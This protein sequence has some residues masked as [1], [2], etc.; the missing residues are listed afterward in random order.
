[1]SWVTED[2]L[3]PRLAIAQLCQTGLASREELARVFQISIRSVQKYVQVFGERGAGGLAAGKRGP[4]GRWK[5]SAALRGEILFIALHEGI[6]DCEGIRRRLEGWGEDVSIPS[7]R[8]VLLENGIRQGISVPE[9]KSQQR[10]LL[11]PSEE[12]GQ[13]WLELG[14][15]NMPAEQTVSPR[16]SKQ[17]EEEPAPRVTVQSNLSRGMRAKRF[18]SRAQRVYLDRLEHGQYSAYAGGLLLIPLVGQYSFLPVLERTLDVGSRQGHA[19]Q[20]LCLTLLYMDVFRF[21]SL[22]DFKRAYRREFG[23]LAGRLYSPSHFTLRRFLHE[24]RKLGKGEEL[25]EQFAGEYLKSGIARWGVLYIDGHFLPYHGMFPITKGW[26]AVRK[27]P[28]KGSYHFIAVDEE[29][30][31]WMFLIRSSSEDLR[32]KIPEI[33]EKVKRIARD[34]GLKEKEAERIIVVFDREGYS[35]ELYRCL[36]GRDKDDGKRRAIFIS[37]AKYTKWVYEIPEEELDGRVVVRYKIRKPKKF[38]Y[39]ETERRMPK[40]GKIRTV[41][42]QREADKKR[43]AIYTNGKAQELKTETVVRIMCRRW[44][45][46]NLIKSLMEKHFINYTP[47]YVREQLAE[48]P[49]VDNPKVLELKKRKARLAGTVHKAKARFTDE[50]L[51]EADEESRLKE[52]KEGQPELLQ[53]IVTTESQILLI[54]LEIDK[55]P[56]KVPFQQAHA[57]KRLLKLNHEKKR[58]LDCIKVFSYNVQMKM[59]ELLLGHYDAPKEILP[60]LSMILNRGG[61]VK[62]QGQQLRVRLRRFT[63]PEIDYAARRLCEDLN[64]L[65]PRTLDPFRHTIHYEIQ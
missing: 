20:Q 22:E 2:D 13:R 5:V 35:G 9:A 12:E 25:M 59:C 28:M 37:W 10:D 41:V 42:V 7:I 58:F 21:R 60:A 26:H 38:K 64:S 61:H 52:L 57:D 6:F 24:V 54:D 63:N 65:N 33:V 14:G 3:S 11:L 44:G 27:I 49:M 15:C 47:G 31:P 16:E 34:V 51:K 40:Y 53:Q 62:L 30:T 32:Q 19:F 29:F 36:D 39:C 50:I 45:E 55:L 8:Q 56:A 46:E 23:L 17:G 1:M 43:A 48:Q 4:K 18:Y